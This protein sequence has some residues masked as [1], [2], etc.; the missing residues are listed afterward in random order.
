MAKLAHDFPT[1]VAVVPE[2]FPIP[3]AAGTPRPWHLLG[4]LRERGAKLCLLGVVADDDRNWDAFVAQESLRT[5]FGEV[6]TVRRESRSS[7][8]AALRTRV[9]GRPALDRRHKNPTALAAA[10]AAA[11]SLVAGH[12][13]AVFYCWTLNALQ[14][15]PE[16]WWPAVALD[17]VD[18]PSMTVER[19]LKS[20]S[21]LSALRRAVLRIELPAL[22][23]Y[24]DRA[25][26]RVGAAITNSSA[27][28]AHLAANHAGVNARLH[29][30][31]DGGDAAY[32]APEPFAA[33]AE[34]SNELV[35]V[36][37]MTFPPNA[38]AAR[39]LAREILPI[40]RRTHPDLK[41][42]L[43]GPDPGGAIA[44]LND[45]ERVVVTGFVDDVRPYLK[46]AAVVVSPL[47]FGAGMKNKLQ[48]GL[49]MEK[50]MVVSPV[51]C[52][53]FDDL[54]PGRDALVASSAPEFAARV[55]ELL[56]SPE[57]RRALGSAG[58]ALIR[59]HYTWPAAVDALVRAIAS[60]EP[61]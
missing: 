10:Q 58:R 3:P 22:R 59:A 36:G 30:V 5:L 28:L 27:D 2:P 49:A 14:W 18:S 39:F 29:R 40:V 12:R 38:D 8:F 16:E 61:V 54:V 9:E 56:E 57:R 37:A 6:R 48:A 35:F 17:L 41:A 31:I 15:V 32:F 42:W 33:V 13:P 1:V 44:D 53:G 52:E 11:R 45:G 60:C 23:S 20:D 34:S 26:R 55:C 46:R 51:T 47:R 24:L 19:R 43:I 25:L 7:L 21:G 50:A 4:G